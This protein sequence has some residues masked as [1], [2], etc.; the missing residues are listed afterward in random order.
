MHDKVWVEL[1]GDI[2][3]ARMRGEPIEETIYCCHEQVLQIAKDTGKFR[4]LLDCL[5]ML[6]PTVSVTIAQQ[7]LGSDDARGHTLKRAIVVPN[8]KLAYLARLAFADG[9][10]RVFYNDLLAAMNW[11]QE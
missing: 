10:N 5:E 2:I 4:V 1:N 6:P 7:K 9:D 3:I 11:L 8:T